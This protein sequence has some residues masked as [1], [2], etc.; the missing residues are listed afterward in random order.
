MF[1]R[2]RAFAGCASLACAALAAGAV[3]AQDI[4]IGAVLP[5]S[6]PNAQY[7]ETFS[8]GINLAV[9]DVNAD[10]MLSKPLAMDY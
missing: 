4:K 10:H 6:G 2:L 3:S 8:T 9:A 1:A 7:G 5:L